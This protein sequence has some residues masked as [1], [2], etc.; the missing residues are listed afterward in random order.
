M[1]RITIET[2]QKERFASRRALVIKQVKEASY[3]LIDIEAEF[4]D[5]LFDEENPKTYQDLFSEF[6]LKYY[7]KAQELDKKTI[8][9]IKVNSSYFSAHYFPIEG[10]RK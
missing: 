9:Y 8:Q 5:E 2:L 3:Q 1:E 4:L 6:S 10:K 7:M